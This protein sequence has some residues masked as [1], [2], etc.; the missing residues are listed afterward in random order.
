M[1]I[2][3]IYPPAPLLH[4]K[5]VKCASRITTRDGFADLDGRPFESYYCAQC[6][7]AMTTPET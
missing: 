4:M 1:K 2:M 5:C 3:P 6:A 7:R